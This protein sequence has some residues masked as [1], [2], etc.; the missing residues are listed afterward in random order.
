[1]QQIFRQKRGTASNTPCELEFGELCPTSP[2]LDLGG[3][4][5]GSVRLQPD[6]DPCESGDG[7]VLLAGSVSSSIHCPRRRTSPSPACRLFRGC[8]RRTVTPRTFRWSARRWPLL[9]VDEVDALHA[10]FADTYLINASAGQEIEVRLERFSGKSLALECIGPRIINPS[11]VRG[12]SMRALFISQRHERIDA[13]GASGRQDRCDSDARQQ[14]GRSHAKDSG[15]GLL[16]AIELVR[17]HLT[18]NKRQR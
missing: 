10:E 15:I 2:A 14:H 1:M 8:V 18:S 11:Q 7:D 13:G 12:Q 17:K 3:R 9:Y 16:N 4:G 5:S 6:R